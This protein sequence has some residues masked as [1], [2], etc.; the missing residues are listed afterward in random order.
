MKKHF[1]IFLIL[2]FCFTYGQKEKTKKEADTIKVLAKTTTT[3]NNSTN[4]D[5]YLA[6]AF[7]VTTP[8]VSQLIKSELIPINYATGRAEYSIPIFEVKEGNISVPVMLKYSSNGVKVTQE[9]TN[10]GLDWVLIAG[11]NVTKFVNDIDD[12]KYRVNQNSSNYPRAE[13]DESSLT[14]ITVY[15]A[16]SDWGQYV[17]KKGRLVNDSDV[18]FMP[19]SKITA[20][21]SNYE[22]YTDMAADTF[23]AVAPG[24]NSKFYLNKKTNQ[25]GN[26]DTRFSTYGYRGHELDGFGNKIY[27]N[28]YDKFD[29]SNVPNK[30]WMG[31]N[32]VFPTECS[33]KLGN[34]DNYATQNNY[35]LLRNN[36]K[37]YDQFQV[38]NAYGNVYSFKTN[39]VNISSTTE[40][41]FSSFTDSSPEYPKSE[42]SIC[43]LIL[44]NNYNID[45]NTWNLDSILDVTSN[46]KVTF[47]YKEF[48]QSQTKLKDLDKG[49]VILSSYII[50]YGNG[51]S[52]INYPGGGISPVDY[53]SN[54]YAQN[55]V[56]HYVEEI[57]WSEG[58]VKFFYD[59]TRSDAFDDNNNV[60]PKR[61]L[62]Q[63]IVYDVNGQIV[64]KVKL[65]YGYFKNTQVSSDLDLRL[66]LDDVAFYD[67][68][69]TFLY[70][71]KLDYNPLPMPSKGT[72]EATKNYRDLFG[73]FKQQSA[74]NFPKTYYQIINQ[75][76]KF[77]NL[78]LNGTTF[79]YGDID[80]T[81]DNQASIGMLNQITTPTGGYF[82]FAYEL[83]RF[84]LNGQE[85]LGGG[86]RVK[87]Q[88]ILDD[89]TART[90]KYK[91]LNDSGASSGTIGSM[92]SMTT[93][94]IGGWYNSVSDSGVASYPAVY[95][96]QQ[97]MPE[98]DDG[99][100]VIYEKVTEEE[101]GK[102]KQVFSFTGFS[103]YPNI[104]PHT[105][106]HTG[107]VYGSRLVANENYFKNRSH[108]RAKL[109]SKEVYGEGAA[110]PMQTETY[111]YKIGKDVSTD[112]NVYFSNS[113]IFK[114]S[115]S[116]IIDN[117]PE[118]LVLYKK[119]NR[120]NYLSISNFNEEQV[121]K[122]YFGANPVLNNGVPISYNYQEPFFL[123]TKEKITHFDGSITENSFA[124]P[125]TQGMQYLINLNIVANSQLQSSIKK[126]NDTDQGKVISTVY[127]NFPS[128]QAD[129]DLK[130][131]GFPLPYADLSTNI[132]INSPVVQMTYDKFDS[133]GN[134]QQ[135]TNREG[136]PTTV[137]WGY[138]QTKPIAKIDGA[139][140]SDIDSSL[141]SSIVNASNNDAA[142]LPNND[143]TTL[144]STLDN[145]RGNSAFAAYQVT[146]YTHDP[147]IGLRSI[148]MPAGTR[149]SYIY[150]NA[151]RLQKITDRA[152]KTV[153]EYK[154]GYVPTVYYYNTSKSQSFT[155]N[156]CSQSGA[157]P[158]P[159]VYT[160]PAG[161]YSSTISQTLADQTALNDIA[162]NGQY[163]ANANGL[164]N[165]TIS[166]SLSFNTSI[167]ISGGGSASVTTN[168]MYKVSF[169]FSS[170]SNSV[171][172]PW[173]TT[174]VKVADIVGNCRPTSDYSSY[175][176]Q[177]Y[178]TIKTNGEIIIRRHLGVSTPNNTSYN[179]ELY[180]PVN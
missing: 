125:L 127:K 39:D 38:I 10:V 93:N 139:K 134:L 95:L 145:F 130:T 1:F 77:D 2:S 74:G 32:T 4:K 24:L 44:K 34:L 167:G 82:Q 56:Y 165:S 29:I 25:D 48:Q 162:A 42:M 83:N 46:K 97:N 118:N 163:Y 5:D 66:R 27:V 111:I 12:N 110:F 98:T 135:F 45:I 53:T 120:N 28:K 136:V 178:Y 138:N 132:L 72:S 84:L 112:F 99:S 22:Q 123:P 6:K 155:K 131:A 37:D 89:Y 8:E 143:E 68:D 109:I 55:T 171:N 164:C 141:I 52:I 96:S 19:D 133:K 73:N 157:T 103:N 57:N 18:E 50:N 23:F 64:K 75:K 122:E 180:F 150:D 59:F 61:A 85:Q 88:K 144:L 94:R 126:K 104:Y 67:K 119:I 106:D 152:G 51:G 173:T 128:S 107:G 146:T 124:Y 170:G 9:S 81:P 151:L 166:C 179:Y 114:P 35:S 116:L 69:D 177:V 65:N 31:W 108:L 154:Y 142:A 121:T 3:T 102:G 71:Y 49:K 80:M 161:K 36:A 168:A 30:G 92:P 156:N 62:S 43:K 78:P 148:T 17:S 100:F 91:Y 159:I 176:G 76:F 174:G 160:V 153:K 11:G 172:L 175:N 140:F 20:A 15:D 113:Y 169:G 40:F 58:K 7:T 79:L 129:A 115:W 158:V 16:S 21:S 26:W 147:L 14:W 117:T 101:T 86:V 41:P 60:N 87:E 137:I 47:T 33:M 105:E 149:E 63:V 90:I 54:K 70:N 13:W